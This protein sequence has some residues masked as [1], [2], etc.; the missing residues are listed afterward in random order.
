MHV[1][2][3]VGRTEGK[4]MV[5]VELSEDCNGR[6]ECTYLRRKRMHSSLGGEA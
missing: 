3:L 2:A 6:I 5:A 4:P 1:Y